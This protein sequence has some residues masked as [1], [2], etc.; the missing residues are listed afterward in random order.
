MP[1][2]ES[3]FTWSVFS[4]NNCQCGQEHSFETE[5]LPDISQPVVI[6]DVWNCGEV[7]YNFF[8]N[9]D[10]EFYAD[11]KHELCP[12]CQTNAMPK[13]QASWCDACVAYDELR[14]E[15]ALYGE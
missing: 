12:V 9:G 5:K 7:W 14:A 2:L 4:D 1:E 8:S 15:R 10:N 13:D 3:K 6:Q 11:P